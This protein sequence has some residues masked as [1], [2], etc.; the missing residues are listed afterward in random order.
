MPMPPFAPARLSTTTCCPI[1]FA[2]SPPITREMMSGVPPGADG[3]RKRI[4][5][6]GYCS[7]PSAIVETT[8]AA[9]SASTRMAAVMTLLCSR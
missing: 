1:C 7:A 2:S 3:T 4:G 9:A 6:F 8:H 5:R